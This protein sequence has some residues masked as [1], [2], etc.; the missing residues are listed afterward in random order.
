MSMSGRRIQ[1]YFYDRFLRKQLAQTANRR[2]RKRVNLDSAQSIG[3]LFD[4]SALKDRDFVLGYADE[5]RDRG[6]KVRL[7]AYAEGHPDTGEFA[8]PCF[9]K[10]Q[11]DWALRPTGNAVAEFLEQRFDLLFFLA[12]EPHLWLEYIAALSPAHLKIGPYTEKTYCFDLMI[13]N[14]NPSN[15][16]QFIQQAESLLKKTNVKHEPAHV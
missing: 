11:V 7:L 4:A 8:F 1:S 5:L 13:E 15:L 9:T 6:K 10:K 14:K 2:E 3:L 16:E 12:T